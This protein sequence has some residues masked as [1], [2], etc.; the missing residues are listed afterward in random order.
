MEAVMVIDPFS[1]TI[2]PA[3]QTGTYDAGLGAYMLKIYN[4]MALAL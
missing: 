2:H 4:Y 3:G 1:Q